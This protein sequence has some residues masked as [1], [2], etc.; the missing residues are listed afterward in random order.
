MEL[1]TALKRWAQSR[2]NAAML[3]AALFQ[4]L[5][6]VAVVCSVVA[7]AALAVEQALQI[8]VVL[9]EKRKCEY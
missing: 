7:V 4:P 8:Q 9:E 1:C 5:A 2:C 6:A 3:V